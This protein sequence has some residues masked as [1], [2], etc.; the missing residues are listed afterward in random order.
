MFQSYEYFQCVVAAIPGKPGYFLVSPAWGYPTQWGES[1]EDQ[2]EQSARDCLNFLD[3]T[4]AE[5]LTL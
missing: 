5:L 4:E 1:H 3:I 2:W